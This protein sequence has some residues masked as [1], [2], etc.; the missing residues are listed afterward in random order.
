MARY[1]PLPIYQAALAAVVH[2]RSAKEK[3]RYLAGAALR[4]QAGNSLGAAQYR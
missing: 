4:F 3:G 1:E 2:L